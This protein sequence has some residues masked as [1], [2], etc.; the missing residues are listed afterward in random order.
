[1]PRR[2]DFFLRCVGFSEGVD[3]SREYID[4]LRLLLQEA[5]N[6]L[7]LHHANTY[8]V[9]TAGSECTVCSTSGVYPQNIF[10][11]IESALS[12]QAS[13]TDQ[14]DALQIAR[15]KIARLE[16][17]LSWALT[18]ETTNT[19]EWMR[20]FMREINRLLVADGD[21]RRCTFD[22]RELRLRNVI[23]LHPE[24]HNATTT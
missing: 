13:D 20:G 4:E 12:R 16:A 8:A 23:Q 19:D 15:E 2:F 17:A 9:G 11:R 21:A 24:S 1:M 14:S 7:V 22:G 10:G 5:A 6:L 18:V 3:V